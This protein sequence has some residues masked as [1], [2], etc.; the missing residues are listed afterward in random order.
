MK[1][2]DPILLYD[3]LKIAGSN[4][5]NIFSRQ[6]KK[7]IDLFLQQLQQPVHGVGDRLAGDG[8][9]HAGEQQAGPGLPPVQDDR[10]M[11]HLVY[12]SGNMSF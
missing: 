2:V 3:S 7:V 5:E 9:P 12:P 4:Q 6:Q 11:E 1:N 10:Y 8:L